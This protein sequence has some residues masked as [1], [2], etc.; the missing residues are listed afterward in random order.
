MTNTPPPLYESLLRDPVKVER[1]QALQKA[2]KDTRYAKRLLTIHDRT[3]YGPI[4]LTVNGKSDIFKI[5]DH[6]ITKNVENPVIIL[7]RSTKENSIQ[8]QI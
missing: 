2:A 5:Y 4:K 7:P 6:L 3:V 1:L 8:D